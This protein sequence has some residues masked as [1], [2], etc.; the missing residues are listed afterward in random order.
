MPAKCLECQ[1]SEKE[2]FSNV[3]TLVWTGFEKIVFSCASVCRF[4]SPIFQWGR[5][6]RFCSFS[7]CLFTLCFLSERGALKS[8][9]WIFENINPHTHTLY[10]Y[11]TDG[12]SLALLYHT[13][14][15]ILPS[16]I[17]HQLK[18]Q[19]FLINAHVRLAITMKS[20]AYIAHNCFRNQ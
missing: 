16:Y 7:L 5:P 13:F 4:I 14:L 19:T 1:K 18:M 11:I 12:T 15:C 17:F 9:Q 2:A 6:Y 3:S 8:L 10:R 20:T